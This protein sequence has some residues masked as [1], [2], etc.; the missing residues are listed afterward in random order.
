MIADR[1]GVTTG[2]A[3]DNLQERG[4]MFVGPAR[5]STRAWSWARTPAPTT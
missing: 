3:L 2:Y 5:R 1:T 4:E